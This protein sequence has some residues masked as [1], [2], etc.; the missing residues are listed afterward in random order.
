GRQAQ[1]RA[2]LALEHLQEV[3]FRH[4]PRYLR[5][6][7]GHLERKRLGS[8]I[9]ALFDA[10]GDEHRAYAALAQRTEHVETSQRTAGG[11][12]RGKKAL[13]RPRHDLA[14]GTRQ[15]GEALERGDG[16]GAHGAGEALRVEALEL[17]HELHQRSALSGERA[18]DRRRERAAGEAG[19]RST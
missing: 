14:T 15:I 3:A 6:E 12:P 2:R 4:V 5:V 8:G 17:R 13:L 18:I 1:E 10:L 7:L 16:E 19:R 11:N 9:V